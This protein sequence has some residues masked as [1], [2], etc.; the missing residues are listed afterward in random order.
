[1]GALLRLNYLWL[2]RDA[3]PRRAH[4]QLVWAPGPATGPEHWQTWSPTAG[5]G[6]LWLEALPAD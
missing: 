1:M 6:H 4:Y 2:D 3:Q 5:V